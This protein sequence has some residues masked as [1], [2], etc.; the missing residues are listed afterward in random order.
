MSK[1]NGNGHPD[2]IPLLLTKLGALQVF[3]KGST[4]THLPIDYVGLKVH[5]E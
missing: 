1:C 3:E 5:I 4:V 2:Y